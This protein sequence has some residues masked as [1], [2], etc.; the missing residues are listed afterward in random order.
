MTITLKSSYLRGAF[1]P[2]KIRKHAKRDLKHV[3]F[4]TVV[5][6]GLSGTLPLAL[7]ADHFGVNYAAIRKEGVPSHKDDYGLFEGTLG[8][9]WLF[10][11]DFISSGHTFNRVLDSIHET[12][13]RYNHSTECVGS[14]EYERDEGNRYKTFDDIQKMYWVIRDHWTGLNKP[15]PEP[16]PEPPKLEFDPSLGTPVDA[17][18]ILA[19]LLKGVKFTVG[20]P[21]PTTPSYQYY[22]Y[23]T[24][25]SWVKL[26]AMK[27]DPVLE[28]TSGT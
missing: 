3:E 4:D 12:A 24:D 23:G 10:V 11:D 8:D 13:R 9:R 25:S 16:K 28:I 20:E 26:G 2:D 7:I 27:D 19:D 6:T 5:G 14:F 1:D 17:D 22:A 18:T 21:T 15:K